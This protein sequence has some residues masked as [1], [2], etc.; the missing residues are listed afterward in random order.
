[1]HQP[2]L[3]DGPKTDTELLNTHPKNPDD[4]GQWTHKCTVSG[5]H[6]IKQFEKL[7]KQSVFI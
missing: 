2:G 1:M 4:W 6:R 3:S 7:E 5:K